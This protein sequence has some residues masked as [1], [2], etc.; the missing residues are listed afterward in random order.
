M[1][2]QICIDTPFLDLSISA[3]RF[4]LRAQFFY[5]FTFLPAYTDLTYIYLRD[6]S[7]AHDKKEILIVSLKK[8][9]RKVE[10]CMN[11]CDERENF[12]TF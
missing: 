1:A 9:R 4:H 6:C 8:K 3:N 5:A 12:V 7:R 10:Q 11:Q 2:Y